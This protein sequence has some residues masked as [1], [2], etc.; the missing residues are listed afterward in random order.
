MAVIYHNPRCSTSR[1]TLELLH[2]NG[3]E[4]TIVEYLKT[5]PSRVEI[6]KLIADAGIEVRR[7]CASASRSTMNS[8]SPTPATTSCSTRWPP[9]RSS[10]SG[11][12]W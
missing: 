7:R 10:S 11:R 9:T 5:P 12:S 2:D 3:I 8:I 4:P 6:D 1:K